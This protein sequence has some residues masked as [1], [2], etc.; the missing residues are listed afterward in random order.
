MDSTDPEAVVDSGPGREA[1]QPKIRSFL[2]WTPVVILALVLTGAT[3]AVVQLG[4]D[5]NAAAPRAPEADAPLE[6]PILSLRRDLEPLRMAAADHTLRRRLD[7]FLASQ[8]SDTCLQVRMGDFAYDHRVDDPQVPASVHK[9]LTAVAALVTLDPASTFTTEVHVAAPPVDGAVGDLFL[10]GGGDPLLATPEYM[11]R[12]QN[13]PQLFTDLGRL[14]DAVVAAGIRNVDGAVV[15]DES[16]Y[17]PIRFNPAWP[18]RFLT[19]GQAGP[20]SALSVNDGFAYFPEDNGV[21]RAAPDPAAYAAEVFARALRA[22]GVMVSGSR[23]GLTPPETTGVAT[24]E[25]PPV[26]EVVAQMLRESDNTTAELLVKELGLRVD[27]AGTTANGTRVVL[28]TL[29]EAGFDVSAATVVDGSGLAPDDTVTCALVGELLSHPPTDDAIEA[30]LPIAGESGTLARRF[31]RPEVAGLLRA[32]TGTLN[33]VTALAGFA[34]TGAAEARFALIAN[35]APDERIAIE[36]IAQQERL[37]DLL[38]A[39]PQLPDL[40]HL[41]P[42]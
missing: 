37:A 13:Q 11:A 8:P 14:A 29:A 7:E 42:G 32:K 18:V 40:D 12:E 38:V 16:R 20:L 17:D 21:F 35:V 34:D 39:Y 1:S 6:T 4:D 3:G 27:G 30:A 2:R 24:I 22:R 23:S 28:A 41:R 19:Q 5:G 10:R 33:Q 36:M 15:G 9:L 25:S 31:T 26:G